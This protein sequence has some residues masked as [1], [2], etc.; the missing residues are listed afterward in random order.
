MGDPIDWDKV[1]REKRMQHPDET[2]DHSRAYP[3]R[4]KKR[5]PKAKK[6]KKTV[7]DARELTGAEVLMDRLTG[8]G[9]KSGSVR[10]RGQARMKGKRKKWGRS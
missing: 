6:P 10:S 5:T 3:E 8:K 2:L 4:P 1:N 7:T 9:K